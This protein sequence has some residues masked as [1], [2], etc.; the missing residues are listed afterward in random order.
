MI[1]LDGMLDSRTHTTVAELRAALDNWPG[2]AIVAVKSKNITNER[3][4][5]FPII[6]HNSLDDDSELMLLEIGECEV[7]SLV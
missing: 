3:V 6:A 2:N 5:Q 4:L 1:M 7:V